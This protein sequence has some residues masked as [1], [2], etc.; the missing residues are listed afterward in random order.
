M[1]ELIYN[2]DI[3]AKAMH[4]PAQASPGSWHHNSTNAQQVGQQSKLKENMT[5]DG[6]KKAQALPKC[7]PCVLWSHCCL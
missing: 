2:S 4:C 3:H 1:C 7:G 6:R 5:H